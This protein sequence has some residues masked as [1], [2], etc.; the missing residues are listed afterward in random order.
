M[1]LQVRALFTPASVAIVVRLAL[2]CPGLLSVSAFPAHAGQ[3]PPSG[4][5]LPRVEPGTV[6]DDGAV[7]HLSP[8]LPRWRAVQ[9]MRLR[10]EG[11][12]LHLSPSRGWLR[13]SGFYTD[14]TFTI[15]FRLLEKDA[16][17][18][19]GIRAP[20]GGP[21]ATEIPISNEGDGVR[22]LGRVRTHD[23]TRQVSFDR[24]AL[25]R[26]KK[27]VG[28]WQALRVEAVRHTVHVFLNDVEI[29]SLDRLPN[30][31]GYITL[32]SRDGRMEIRDAQIVRHR[33]MSEG[34]GAGAIPVTEPE[35]RPRPL[36]RVEPIYP[37][38]MLEL[39]VEGRVTVEF[40][41]ERDGTVGDVRI[42]QGAHPDLEEA[43]IGAVRQW[44]FVPGTKDGAPVAV[45]VRVTV[46]F[47]LQD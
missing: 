9:G 2:F 23:P 27:R 47:K 22:A 15:L 20:S 21:Y 40:I 11:A 16:R 26:A 18:D 33:V 3:T 37:A 10:E 7:L 29:S 45:V 24:A 34:F 36:R 17:A 35:L 6:R 1:V 43:T 5:S 32:A 19:L 39:G 28:E 14:F 4:S 42:V 25:A 46:T 12:V 44:T 38:R 8:E 41:V 30:P 31:S 13:T